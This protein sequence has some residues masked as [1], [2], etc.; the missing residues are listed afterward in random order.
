MPIQNEGAKGTL[1]VRASARN[2]TT[3]IDLY[4]PIDIQPESRSTYEITAKWPIEE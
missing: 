3:P 2:I 4:G 1:H